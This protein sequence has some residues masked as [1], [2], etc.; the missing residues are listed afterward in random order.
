M[1]FERNFF[2]PKFWIAFPALIDWT[3]SIVLLWKTR[4]NF[5]SLH[6]LTAVKKLAAEGVEDNQGKQSLTIELSRYHVTREVI[7]FSLLCHSC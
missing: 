4:E 1:V 2:F 7:L 3:R 5:L 6:Q